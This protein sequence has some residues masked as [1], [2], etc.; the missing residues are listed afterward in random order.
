MVWDSLKCHP[1]PAAPA[2]V[3]SAGEGSFAGG[4]ELPRREVDTRSRRLWALWRMEA[5]AYEHTSSKHIQSRYG[6]SIYVYTCIR[7]ITSL[8][9][10]DND[11]DLPRCR[12]TK[13][14]I[15]YREY[16]WPYFI[17]LST[18]WFN[19]WE[20]FLKMEVI[21][22]CLKQ[23][24]CFVFLWE[25][26]NPVAW[27]AVNCLQT[28]WMICQISPSAPF[29]Y[30]SW[31]A[32]GPVNNRTVLLLMEEILQHRLH[33]R[34]NIYT[35]LSEKMGYSSHKLV[36]SSTSIRQDQVSVREVCQNWQVL[37]EYTF[38]ICFGNVLDLCQLET[39]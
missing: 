5:P 10:N 9:Y 38:T 20:P 8:H 26:D 25:Q 16:F 33:I 39:C 36:T 37:S 3:A 27:V 19:S 34:I 29:D 4:E 15:A 28:V 21:S 17:R 22:R 18:S 13:W 23:I 2:A 7:C 11:N 6:W 24:M 12:S 32:K 35:E 14:G 1:K 30:C 31:G